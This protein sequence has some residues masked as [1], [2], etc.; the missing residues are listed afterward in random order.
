MRIWGTAISNTRNAF[1]KMSKRRKG[2]PSESK[3]KKGK[4]IV[5][6]EKELLEKLGR[7]DPCPCG[8]GKRFQELLHD[9]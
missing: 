4:R 8:S 2:F 5:H 9:R 1:E 6:G 7:N 3:V